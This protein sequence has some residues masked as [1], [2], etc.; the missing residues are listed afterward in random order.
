M[1][2]WYA[3]DV[4]SLWE[5]LFHLFVA[6]SVCFITGVF[7]IVLMC[8]YFDA[9]EKF[10]KERPI[11]KHLKELTDERIFEFVEEARRDFEDDSSSN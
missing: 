6:I 4:D 1:L 2:N 9:K 3:A 5:A 11:K 7:A 10:K 8:L